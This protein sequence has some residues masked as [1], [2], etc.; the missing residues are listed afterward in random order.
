MGMTPRGVVVAIIDQ[1]H[2]KLSRDPTKSKKQA[3]ATRT[4]RIEQDGVVKPPTR[5]A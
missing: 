3:A 4:E 2:A 1:Y 5:E